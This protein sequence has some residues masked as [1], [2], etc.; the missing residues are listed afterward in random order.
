MLLTFIFTALASI[1]L[2]AGVLLS[3]RIAEQEKRD[4]SARPC[5]WC[6]CADDVTCEERRARKSR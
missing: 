3:A 4:E 5:L 1:A 6:G 2:L